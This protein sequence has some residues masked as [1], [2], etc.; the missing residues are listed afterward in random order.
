MLITSEK[1]V[2]KLAQEFVM[3]DNFTSIPGSYKQLMKS[4]NLERD[5]WQLCDESITNY[6]LYTDYDIKEFIKNRVENLHSYLSK[7]LEERITIEKVVET[8]L[9]PFLNP[10]QK[11][12]LNH[13][14]G[15]YEAWIEEKDM[16][17]EDSITGRYKDIISVLEEISSNV[18]FLLEED[19][20]NKDVLKKAGFSDSAI[21]AK[22][23]LWLVS[24]VENNEINHISYHGEEKEAQE[25]YVTLCKKH[26]NSDAIK[27]LETP[28]EFFEYSQSDI[29]K[30]IDY[31]VKVD[32][33]R[34]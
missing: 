4:K 19:L 13:V 25:L 22:K 6:G 29:Y 7:S 8:T 34:S 31:A 17:L 24:V 14:D 33:V 21:S 23:D 32:M 26:Y 5:G 16:E 3:E 2:Q 15:E 11:V 28:F 20:D 9:N 12:V 1:K 27:D 10:N 30:D 18:F